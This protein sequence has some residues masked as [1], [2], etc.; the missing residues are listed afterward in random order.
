[1]DLPQYRCHKIVSAFRITEIGM[2]GHVFR[3]EGENG[4][5]AEVDQAWV[6]RHK[7]EVG[8]WFVRYE[9]GYESVSP[10]AA[11]TAGYT[12]VDTPAVESPSLPDPSTTEA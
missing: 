1:M 10:D 9:D 5:F 2:A 8:S 11:F 7:P 12:L 3:M 6:G 4:L